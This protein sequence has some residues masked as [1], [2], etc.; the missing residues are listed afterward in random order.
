VIAWFDGVDEFLSREATP[1]SNL[2]ELDTGIGGTAAR[3]VP[4]RMALAADDHIVARAGQGQ[5][6]DLVGHGAG[7]EPEGGLFSQH[8]G[9]ARLKFVDG[10]VFAKLIVADRS[11]GHGGAHSFSW[12]RN[13]VGAEIDHGWN[14]ISR[15]AVK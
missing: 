4:H 15:P 5:Q 1:A 2:R 13:R 14:V 3:L 12:A 11:S 10:R 6:S 8:R 7:G 9:D